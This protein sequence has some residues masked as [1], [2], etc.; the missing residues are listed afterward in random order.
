MEKTFVVPSFWVHHDVK[1]AFSEESFVTFSQGYEDS[2]AELRIDL[3]IRQSGLLSGIVASQFSDLFGYVSL[4]EKDM[5]PNIPVATE[6][7]FLLDEV[8]LN[9]EHHGAHGDEIM[10]HNRQIWDHLS[11]IEVPLIQKGQYV[12]AIEIP[13]AHWFLQQNEQTCLSLDLMLE[14]IPKESNFDEESQFIND[15]NNA[16]Y[17]MNVFPPAKLEMSLADQLSIR[18]HVDRPVDFN[19]FV[20]NTADLAH[21]CQLQSVTDHT[22][23]LVP[24]KHN[25][26]EPNEAHLFFDFSKHADMIKRVFTTSA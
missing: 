5:Y 20:Q 15:D 25:Y 10:V 17:I 4:F 16:Y 18:F 11:T 12:L 6:K 1:H 21:L 13:I 3:D 22:K 19:Q 26:G 24:T 9:T 8:E 23:S 2:I 14:F 7:S